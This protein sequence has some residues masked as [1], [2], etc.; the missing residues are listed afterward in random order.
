MLR[1]QALVLQLGVL[2]TYDPSKA[3][4]LASKV[5]VPRRTV[6]QVVREDHTRELVA[7]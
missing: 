7:L 5:L 2:L 3:A 1:E 4:L 6:D